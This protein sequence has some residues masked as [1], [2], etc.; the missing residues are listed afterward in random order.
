[1]KRISISVLA[2]LLLS[3]SAMAFNF[4][5][6]DFGDSPFDHNNNWAPIEYPSGVGNLPSPGLLGEGGEAFDLEG[7]KVAFE[8]DYVYVALANSFGYTATSTAW[9]QTYDLGDL[10]IGK[11]GGG[12][13]MA[14]D[15]IDGGANGLYSVGASTGIPNIPGT[16]YGTSI[17]SQIGEFQM[18]Q[19]SKLGDV[20]SAVSFW[21]DYET[22]YLEPG[23]GDTYL[24]EF[25]FEKSLLGDFKS[26]DF[27]ITLGC[28]NDLIEESVGA[29]PEP[30]TALLFGLGLLGAAAVRRRK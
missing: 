7:L 9:G 2:I 20:T 6:Y 21:D 24:W 17:A 27:H 11:D 13:D 4:S 10:F 18:T 1:M 22:G 28:G 12:Y 3:S 29:V 26:L 30:A 5:L 25:C 19:G 16:Y 8:G 14:I 23:N 15:L